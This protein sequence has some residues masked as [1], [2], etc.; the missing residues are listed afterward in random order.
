MTAARETPAPT[1][2]PLRLGLL[3]FLPCLTGKMVSPS[4]VR[5]PA[6]TVSVGDE[7][8]NTDH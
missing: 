4:K 3:A 2:T 6:A 8:H 7:D 1:S 5:A